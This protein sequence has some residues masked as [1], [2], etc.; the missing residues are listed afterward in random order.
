VITCKRREDTFAYFL[1]T[2]PRLARYS[3]ANAGNS[4]SYVGTQPPLWEGMSDGR[5]GGSRETGSSPAAGLPSQ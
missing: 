5:P 1:S 2:S 4:E 3:R